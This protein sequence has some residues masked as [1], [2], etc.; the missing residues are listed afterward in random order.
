[1][2]RLRDLIDSKDPAVAELARLI[3]AVGDL[4]PPRGA[5]DR[6][7]RA[8]TERQASRWWWKPVL[9]AVLLFAIIPAAVAG[10]IIRRWAPASVPMELQKGPGPRPTGVPGRKVHSAAAPKQAP[11]APQIQEP[12]APQNEA[13]LVSQDQAPQAPLASA[14]PVSEP[15]VLSPGRSLEAPARAPGNPPAAEHHASQPPR[16]KLSA[17][18]DRPARRLARPPAAPATSS[19]ARLG[20]SRPSEADPQPQAKPETAKERPGEAALLLGALRALRRDHDAGA[21][22]KLLEA[23]RLRFPSGDLAEEALAVTIEASAALD[24]R[25]TLGLAKEYLSRYPRGRF[26]DEVK[27]TQHR[28]QGSQ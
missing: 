17:T 23:Y 18:L 12:Q 1:M 5:Q 10:V 27:R 19:P 20:E 7:R 2:Q 21:A 8:M 3:L 9:V 6:V 28:F 26:C 24:D 4:D 11:Q 25:A 16:R 22:L 15:P 14:L 13:P